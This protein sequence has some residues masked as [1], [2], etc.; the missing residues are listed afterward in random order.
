M[1]AVPTS[2]E[3]GEKINLS[4]TGVTGGRNYG[5]VRYEWRVTAGTISGSGLTAVLDTTGAA[6]GSTIDSHGQC[7]FRSRRML[8]Q[9]LDS[10]QA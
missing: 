3:A 6:P 2:A 4:T 7:D 5:S 1:T 9:R 8:G 10:R